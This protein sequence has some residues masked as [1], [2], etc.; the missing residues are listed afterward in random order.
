M[1]FNKHY[2]LAT[3]G[4]H[5]FLSASKYSWLN[6]DEDKLDSVFS[7]SLAAEK[8]TRLHK[9]AADLI[10]EGVKLPRSEQTLNRYVN[11]AIGFRMTPEQI[12]FYSDNAYGTADSISFR[13][14]RGKMK[15]RVHDL[16]TGINPASFSQLDIY[17]AFFCLEYRI[18]PFEIE[19]EWRIYQNDEAHVQMGDPDVITHIMEKIKIFD[20]RINAMRLEAAGL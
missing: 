8:G 4:S 6:Y 7:T 5:A 2:A 1:H 20:K 11:D 12:L 3:A 19:M 15:L 9:L 18:K 13:Q 17:G 10:R 14:E 16:K